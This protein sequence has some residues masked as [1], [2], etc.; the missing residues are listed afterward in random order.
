MESI[1]FNCKD[2]ESL[3]KRIKSLFEKSHPRLDKTA[4]GSGKNFQNYPLNPDKL[5]DDKNDEGSYDFIDANEQ[6]PLTE[7]GWATVKSSNGLPRDLPQTRAKLEELGI[8][9]FRY[10][11][12][13]NKDVQI[14]DGLWEGEDPEDLP[15]YEEDTYY[16][17]ILDTKNGK[18]VGRARAHPIS[19]YG[20]EQETGKKSEFKGL[21]KDIKYM[22]IS[23]VD[24]NPMYRGQKCCDKLVSFIMREISKAKPACNHFVIFNASDTV[25]GIPACRC[26]VKSGIASGFK[27]HEEQWESQLP[28][29]RWVQALNEMTV[30]KCVGTH[31]GMPDIYFYVKNPSKG[32]KKK[33]KNKKTHKIKRK[34]KKYKG[35][36]YKTKNR[37]H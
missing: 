17:L 35:R 20:L 5:K 26:Y 4:S 6:E 2:Y 14:R 32:G 29:G 12:K 24:I 19:Q 21:P 37:K 27:V 22:Y 1:F 7:L 25:D 13:F 23:R 16:A 8:M 30:D 3:D 10:Q 33:N 11:L 18:V 15:C 31:E 34:S 36:K 28:D 9:P